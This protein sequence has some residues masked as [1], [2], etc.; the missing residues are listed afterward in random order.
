MKDNDFFYNLNQ[1]ESTAKIAQWLSDTAFQLINKSNGDLFVDIQEYYCHSESTLYVIK[2]KTLVLTSRT[3][4]N[5]HYIVFAARNYFDDLHKRVVG[6]V[7][8]EEQ[9]SLNLKFKDED[10]KV[11]GEYWVSF[12]QG[13]R[14]TMVILFDKKEYRTFEKKVAARKEYNRWRKL[15]VI[16]TTRLKRTNIVGAKQNAV[17]EKVR[18]ANHVKTF[19]TNKNGNTK[20]LDVDVSAAGKIYVAEYP[21]SWHLDRKQNSRKVTQ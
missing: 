2:N 9:S 7:S 13:S 16:Y 12:R 10:I 8:A 20:I 5:Q 4:P 19:I 18:T 1:S 15:Q 3:N 14:N 21:H 6:Y 11:V 17:L